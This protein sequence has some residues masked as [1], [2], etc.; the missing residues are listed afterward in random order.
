MELDRKEM[1]RRISKRRKVLGIKQAVLAEKIGVNGNH[2]SSVETGKVTPSL[3]LFVKICDELGVTPD[4][5]LEGAMHSNNVPQ[6]IV[7]HLRL[8]SEE[9]VD[10]A[11]EIVKLLADRN[12]TWVDKKIISRYNTPRK[13]GGFMCVFCSVMMIQ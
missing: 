13:K 2:L 10:L 8:C 1:G 12:Q 9:D 4:Y 7:D 11:A 3:E 5:L 6:S